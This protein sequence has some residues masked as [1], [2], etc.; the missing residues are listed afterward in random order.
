DQIPTP[1]S[2]T[3][4]AGRPSGS[5]DKD[6]K[7][8]FLSESD[9]EHYIQ[10]LNRQ[11]G[12]QGRWVKVAPSAD[13]PRIESA[14]EMLRTGRPLLL[15]VLCLA[16]GIA[17]SRSTGAF[18]WLFLILQV[19]C[20]AAIALM[21]Y[22]SIALERELADLF[23]VDAIGMVPLVSVVAMWLTWKFFRHHGE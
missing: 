2:A 20:A 18:R 11:T 13:R 21:I 9:C 4:V 10:R 12:A 19:G 1:T 16:F 14:Q 5:T 3:D 15:A 22:Y 7:K 17:F 6:R 23:A 8:F